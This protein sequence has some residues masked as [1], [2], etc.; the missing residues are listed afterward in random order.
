MLIFLFVKLVH[1]FFSSWSDFVHGTCCAL[2]FVR[3]TI[4]VFILCSWN[5][6]YVDFSSRENS[7]WFS[8][9]RNWFCSRNFFCGDFCS[10]NLLRAEFCSWNWFYSWNLFRADF[11]HET[12]CMLIFLLEKLILS[13]EYFCLLIFACGTC[14]LLIFSRETCCMLIF[15]FVKLVN[16]SLSSLNSFCSWNLLNANFLLVELVVCSFLLVEL[17]AC[18][19]LFVKL[20]HWFSSSWNWFYSWNLLRADF[21]CGTCCVLIFPV[22]NWVPCLNWLIGVRWNCLLR[23]DVLKVPR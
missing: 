21:V 1:W 10:W 8:S 12:S 13:K 2:I 20:V 15:R 5:L 17:V 14:C 23:F 4:L 11:V 18:W 9:S 19:F 16:L 6:L 3:G 7:T 22:G